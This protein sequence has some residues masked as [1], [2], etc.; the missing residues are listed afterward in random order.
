MTHKVSLPQWK[1]NINRGVAVDM[2]QRAGADALQLDFGGGK[3]GVMLD[4]A[5]EIDSV[6]S[7]DGAL[8]FTVVAL[9]YANDLGIIKP[10]GRA[11]SDLFELLNRAILCAKVFGA[12]VIH[13]P[14]FRA[15]RIDNFHCLHAT[16]LALQRMCDL[17]ADNG[18]SLDFESA[19]DGQNSRKIV[20]LT[21]RENLSV[22]V[23]VGNLGSQHLP[24]TS[25]VNEVHEFASPRVHLKDSGMERDS[26]NQ[27][28]SQV[29][30]MPFSELLLE[31]DY[32]HGTMF[33]PLDVYSLRH[34]KGT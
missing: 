19:L 8:D 25:F 1:L 16:A 14:A 23:D 32:L 10:D 4:D 7:A 5:A 29:R 3:R 24:V 15:S 13:L 21:E 28:M 33:R 12:G 17:A 9:N 30:H 22:V 27:W 34:W 18:M 20:E 26:I 6:L 11:N 31:R 2:C